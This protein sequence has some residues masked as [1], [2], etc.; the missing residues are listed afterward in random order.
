MAALAATP[1]PQA[2]GNP[3]GAV[4]LIVPIAAGGTSDVLAR[5]IADRLKVDLGRAVVVDNR[6]GAYGRTAI[7]ALNHAAPDGDTLLLAPIAVPVLAPLLYKQ[8][9]FEPMTDL[10]PVAQITTY[11]FAFAVAAEQSARSL[12]D[13]IEWARGHPA[14]S[15]FGTP[16]AGSIPHL[17]GTLLAKRSGIELL[18]VPYRSAALVETDLIGGR[19]AAGISAES[20]FTALYRAGRL[21]ILATSGRLRSRLFPEVPT[22]RELGFETVEGAGWHAIFAPAGTPKAVIDRWSASIRAALGNPELREKLMA[23]G[24]QPTGTT[25]EQLSEIMVSST[26]HWGRIIKATGFSGQ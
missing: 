25:P 11:E 15:T 21:R 20:D 12:P 18:H 14:R 17:L 23:L 3:A 10:G 16:G 22:F 2:Q 4:R 19:I 26:D 5:L 7:E 13:F 24:L 6:P 9:G 1:E 8:L